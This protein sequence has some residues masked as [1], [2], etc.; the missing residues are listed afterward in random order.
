MSFVSALLMSQLAFNFT[1]C[2][3]GFKSALVDLVR[4]P[5][6]TCNTTTFR[7]THYFR[8]LLD[9]IS[10]TSYSIA[11]SRGQDIINFL[12]YWVFSWTGYHQLPTLLGLLVDGIS[13]TS[14]SIGSSNGQDISNFLLYWGFSWTGYPQLPTLLG[15]H[16]DRISATSYCIWSLRT[17]D[18]ISWFKNPHP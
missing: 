6:F 11:S 2:A 5:N 7:N 4:H 15:L 13:A 10:A 12:L 9:R 3:Q 1:Q 17:A 18:L 8:R 14:Y 16:V